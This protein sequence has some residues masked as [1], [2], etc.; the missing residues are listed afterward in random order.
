M[1][2][3]GKL[4]CPFCRKEIPELTNW[5]WHCG[6][7]LH[8]MKFARPKA[9]SKSSHYRIVPDGLQFAIALGGVIK[10][11]GLE[12]KNAESLLEILNSVMDTEEAG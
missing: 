4:L 7:D 12:L 9:L 11:H 1:Q 5:C 10:I 2:N 3:T 8:G 6:C